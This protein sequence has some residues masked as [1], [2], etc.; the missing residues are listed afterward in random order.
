MPS[1]NEMKGSIFLA[2]LLSASCLVYS[3]KCCIEICRIFVLWL[4]GYDTMQAGRWI[5]EEHT[6]SY[7]ED[8]GRM[9]LLNVDTHLSDCTMSETIRSP[10]EFPQPWKSQTSYLRTVC[11]VQACTSSPCARNEYR[12]REHTVQDRE[13]ETGSVSY[14][15]AMD[16]ASYLLKLNNQ[17]SW[18]GIVK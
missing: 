2:S 1:C 8:E 18:K 9:F 5:P 17:F 12:N 15:W 7:H 10:Y 13:H 16:F 3:S 14:K 4:L 6:A 11:E